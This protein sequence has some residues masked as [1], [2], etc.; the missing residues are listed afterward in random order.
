MVLCEGFP[1]VL[2]TLCD[3]E[4]GNASGLGVCEDRERDMVCLVAMLRRV[5]IPPVPQ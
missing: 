5:G 4:L 1:C 3:N 2:V